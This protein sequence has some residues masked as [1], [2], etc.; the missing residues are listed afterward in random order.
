MDF[1]QKSLQKMVK[2]VVRKNGSELNTKSR[3]S[4]RAAC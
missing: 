4:K 3:P 2:V 1:I